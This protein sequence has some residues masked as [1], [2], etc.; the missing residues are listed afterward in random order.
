MAPNPFIPEECYDDLATNRTDDDAR[1]LVRDDEDKDPLPDPLLENLIRRIT[2]PNYSLEAITTA[3]NKGVNINGLDETGNT[4]LTAAI[5]R[6][7]LDIVKLLIERGADMK[8]TSGYQQTDMP[9]LVAVRV[10][11]TDIMQELIDHGAPF[12]AANKQGDTPLII[13]I[14]R[15]QPAA[16]T[17]LLDHGLDV[18]ERGSHNETPLSVAAGCGAE[19]IVRLLL[20]R[21]ADATLKTGVNN[22]SALARAAEADSPPIM[23]MLI[24]Q[25]A[26]WDDPNDWGQTPLMRAIRA[27]SLKSVTFLLEKGVDLARR[28]IPMRVEDPSVTDGGGTSYYNL[29]GDTPLLLATHSRRQR[30]AI[31]KALLDAHANVDDANSN[32]ETSLIRVAN[33]GD[34]DCIELLIKAGADLFTKDAGGLTAI[35][36]ARRHS[37]HEIIDYL[38]AAMREKLE[39]LCDVE[40]HNARRATQDRQERLKK[41]APK[42]KL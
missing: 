2:A 22:G 21:G 38:D 18:N 3:L 24:D 11:A 26:E 34:M 4:P 19:E 36:H 7:R 28:D 32:G 17:F 16:I 42:F 40:E 14:K 23:Q 10:G 20:D 15:K 30:A 8:Q 31:V 33:T 39:H 27:S 1:F 5:R 37:N 9:F 25:G 13:A 6:K 29:R 12:A 35:D 41:T